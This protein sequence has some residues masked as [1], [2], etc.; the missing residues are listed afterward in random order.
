MIP[1][2]PTTIPFCIDWLPTSSFDK[3]SKN[4]RIAPFHVRTSPGTLRP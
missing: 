3:R 4:S 2:V 1:D